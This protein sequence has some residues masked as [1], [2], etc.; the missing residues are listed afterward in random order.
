MAGRAG[1][2]ALKPETPKAPGYNFAARLRKTG[3]PAK[4][5]QFLLK[6][7]DGHKTR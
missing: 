4:K 1:R 3:R 5:M 7:I 2:P 6:K